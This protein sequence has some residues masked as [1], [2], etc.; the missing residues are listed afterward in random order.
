MLVVI[1]TLSLTRDD[2]FCDHSPIA[3]LVWSTAPDF[4]LTLIRFPIP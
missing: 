1:D 3:A 2:G 4:M